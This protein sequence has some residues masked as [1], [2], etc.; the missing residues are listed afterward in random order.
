MPEG[1]LGFPRM[2]SL[3]PLVG[4][5]L[6]GFSQELRE[7]EQIAKVMLDIID[8]NDIDRDDPEDEEL[9]LIANE[10]AD[11]IYPPDNPVNRA[12]QARFKKCLGNDWSTNWVDGLA[13]STNALPEDDTIGRLLFQIRGCLGV[14]ESNVADDE[15]LIPDQF[16]E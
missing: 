12:K 14:T 9:I 10:M 6:F 13:E 8:K 11:I 15:R 1:P 2:T 5:S 3:G 4:E 7:K 16:K